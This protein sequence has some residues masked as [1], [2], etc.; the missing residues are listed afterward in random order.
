MYRRVKVAADLDIFFFQGLVEPISRF[1][2]RGFINQN[3]KIFAR[4]AIARWNALKAKSGDGL[5][6]PLIIESNLIA[7]IDPRVET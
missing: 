7:A 3:C 1:A 5:E 2:E 6:A 4:A